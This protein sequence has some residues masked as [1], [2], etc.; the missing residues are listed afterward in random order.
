[1]SGAESAAETVEVE[2]VMS[3]AVSAAEA[4]AAEEVMS[5]AVSTAETVAVEEIMSEAVSAAEAVTV[6]EVMS[7]AESASAAAEEII[8]E[9]GAE[10]VM[11]IIS[12]LPVGE[13]VTVSGAE[14][15]LSD[16]EFP[17]ESTGTESGSPFISALEPTIEALLSALSGEET[18]PET[19]GAE[20]PAAESGAESSIAEIVLE[21]ESMAAGNT[22][23]VSV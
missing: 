9:S 3:E 12:T 16:E 13:P 1:M 11:E 15:A 19:S 7:E 17:A 8:T 23:S 22:D 21:V 18:M 10:S 20:I 4:A 14:R 6:E 5:E 2:E